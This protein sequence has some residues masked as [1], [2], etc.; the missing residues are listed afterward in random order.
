MPRHPAKPRFP[1]NLFA[2]PTAAHQEIFYTIPRAGHMIA[3]PDHRMRRVHFPGHE[4][5]LCRSGRG[6]AR[7]A[8]RTHGVQPGDLVWINCHHPHE[9]GGLRSEPWEVF[10]IRIEG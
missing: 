8:G 3:S 1:V 10:W 5:I 9:H 4:L 2:T 7:I 6:W